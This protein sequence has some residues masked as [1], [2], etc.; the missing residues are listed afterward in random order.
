MIE[1]LKG[2]KTYIVA[3]IAALYGAAIQFGWLPNEP[4]VWGVLN[5]GGLAALRAGISNG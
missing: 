2:V 5:A 1:G 4:A 3:L